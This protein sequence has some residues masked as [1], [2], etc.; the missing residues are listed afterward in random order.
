MWS[1]EEVVEALERRGELWSVAPGLVGLRGEALALRRELERRIDALAVSQSSEEWL[2]PPALPLE[3]LQRADYFASFPQWL[4]AAA[5][6]SG[7]ATALEEVAT[8]REPAEAARRALAPAGA[9]LSP[10]VCYHVYAALAGKVVSSPTLLTVGGT[11]WRHEG[12]RFRPLERGWA[13]TMR[14]IVC[15]G[16][17]AA[18]EAFRQRLLERARGLA[19]SLGLEGVVEVA[20]DPFYAPTSRGRALLQRVKAL[21]HELLLPIGPGARVA[22]ASANHHETFFG[23]AFDIRLPDGRPAQSGCAA[24]G[25]E[26]WLLAYLCVHG[27]GAR[28]SDPLPTLKG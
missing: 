24:F 15:L 13:F 17:G 16:D 2:V 12:E 21:K 22:A 14:E 3:T 6:L 23:E 5:H 18:V 20:S 8:A 27:P 7:D 9:A 10:A 19:R 4:T 1:A 11:C 26:R 25:I 28:L